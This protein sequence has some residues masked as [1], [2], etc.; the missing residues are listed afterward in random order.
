MAIIKFILIVAVLIV[1]LVS[2][3]L[4]SNDANLFQAPGI[5]QRLSIFLKTNVAETSDDPILEEL[6][7]PIFDISAESLQKRVI[8]A[9]AALRWEVVAQDSENQN[10]NILVR[11]PVLLFED[12][13]FVQVQFLDTK[14]SSLYI[15]SSSQKGRADFAANSGHIQ[16]LIAKIKN[17]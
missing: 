13:V 14:K 16:S 12:D 15:R 2:F 11:S 1:A 8:K 6:R 7:T 10:L 9:A 4:Y 17:R 3:I 5:G